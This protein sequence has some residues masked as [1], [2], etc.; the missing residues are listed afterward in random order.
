MKIEGENRGEE[1]TTPV[2]MSCLKG[3]K[4]KWVKKKMVL[5]RRHISRKKGGGGGVALALKV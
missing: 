3:G 5:Y 2:T 4:Q 1:G